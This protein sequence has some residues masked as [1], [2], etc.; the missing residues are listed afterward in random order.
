MDFGW[1]QNFLPEWLQMVPTGEDLNGED[2]KVLTAGSFL[3]DIPGAR[4]WP[5]WVGPG[6]L[7]VD[8]VRPLKSETGVVFDVSVIQSTKA[9][10]FLPILSKRA[11]PAA[12]LKTD[13]PRASP[14]PQ[15]SAG[16]PH[17]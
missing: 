12:V 11:A 17:S 10:T 9:A 1:L 3:H 7:S 16:V 13:T 14:H 15:R 6:S 4:S 5:K 8:C 2:R